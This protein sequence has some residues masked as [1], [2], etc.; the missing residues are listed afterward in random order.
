MPR[1]HQRPPQDSV[2]SILLAICR[3][4]D[5]D[6]ETLQ[7]YFD[8]LEDEWTEGARNKVLHL[9]RSRDAAA[10]TAAILI[11]AEVASEDDLEELEDLVTDPTLSDLAKLALAPVLKELGS[12]MVDDGMVE[13]LNDPASAMQQMQMRLLELVGKSEMGIESILQDVIGMPLER[14]LAFIS[15]LGSC[16]DARAAQLL[17]PLLEN[18]P[19]KVATAVIEALEQLGP[20]ALQQSLPALN[21]VLSTS[22]PRALKQQARATLGRLM[23]QSAS[24]VDSSPS[25]DIDVMQLVPHEA[26]ASYI[27]GT[28]SQL[29]MLSWLRPDGLLK[30]I[31]VLYQ[32]TVGIKDCYGIDGMDKARR[33]SL[34]QDLQEQGFF[35]FVVP[36]DF[37]RALILQASETSKRLRRKLPISY[38]IWRSLLENSPH[39]DT[40]PATLLAP[41]AL[42]A[43]T[44]A[45]AK[46]G[47]ELFQLPEFLSWLY[48]P[49]ERTEP[50][51]ARYLQF[52][53][54][55]APS[56]GARKLTVPQTKKL[57][58]LL[59]ELV[60]EAL[61][62]LI[63]DHWRERF[64][65]R[66]RLQAKLFQIADREQDARLAQAAAAV[67][68]PASQVPVGEQDFLRTLVRMSI[69]QGPLRM[70]FASLSQ[71]GG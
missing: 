54:T 28:G 45:L 41:H 8:R 44:L 9:L 47:G 7:H 16:N 5:L 52:Y 61:P 29:V 4:D 58:R 1:G 15:W 40:S 42:D 26:R 6:S 37:A 66:L 20:V 3:R 49:M 11:L 12:E 17:I 69:E 56:Q 38:V 50:F 22:A 18:Q 23:M 60:D 25:Q 34:V 33:A 24:G 32:D 63:D 21:Y 10:H 68:S 64:E 30:G 55:E 36:F 53:N 14:R 43:E 19:V 62:E 48:D 2:D 27:D 35:S 46:R 39:E 57:Q 71:S 70:M 31:N 51:I 67:L 65:Q 59:E 13:Y